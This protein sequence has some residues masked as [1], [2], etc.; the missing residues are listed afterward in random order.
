[1]EKALSTRENLIDNDDL[2]KF[3]KKE[4][5]SYLTIKC[6]LHGLLARHDRMFMASGIEGRLPFCSNNILK[7][8][9]CLPSNLIHHNNQGK[10]VL[11]NLA[12]KYFD[13]DF[14]FRKKIGFSSPFGDWCADKTIGVIITILYQK[15]FL[16][17]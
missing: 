10:V 15:I 5:A 11:K 1:M 8:R 17:I 12:L 16:M 2:K 9:I 7:S 3:N 4:Q 13:N 6:Y 14:V